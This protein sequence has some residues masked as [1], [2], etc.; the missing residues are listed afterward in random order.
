MR[1][2]RTM[3]GETAVPHGATAAPVPGRRSAADRTCR[4]HSPPATPA[5]PVA[6][7][8]RCTNGW[9]PKQAAGRMRKESHASAGSSRARG[10][11]PSPF[12]TAGHTHTLDQCSR[13]S[14][15]STPSTRPSKCSNLTTL[16]GGYGSWRPHIQCCGKGSRVLISGLPKPAV[17]SCLCV[18][19]CEGHVILP[20][21]CIASHVGNV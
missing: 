3:A 6:E 8:S 18:C 20:G 17:C 9:K 19:V 11:S 13:D 16:G 12:C 4:A 5:A 14:G 1:A 15:V 7:T 21:V 2:G 10:S